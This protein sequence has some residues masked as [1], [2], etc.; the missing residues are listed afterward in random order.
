MLLDISPT[1]S[2]KGLSIEQV[3]QIVIS[4]CKFYNFGYYQLMTDLISKESSYGQD[5]TCGDHGKSCG[6]YQIRIGTWGDFQRLTLRYDLNH[7]SDIDQID[8][9]ILALKA[10]MW[11]HWGPLA[12]TYDSNPIR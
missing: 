10:G 8:M 5:R 2:L 4:R 1:T 6:V 9:T 12:D 11:H 7:E 3:K